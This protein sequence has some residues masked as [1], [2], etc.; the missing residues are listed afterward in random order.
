MCVKE[1]LTKDDGV[2]LEPM[3]KVE[4][5]VPD[6]YLGDIVGNLNAKRGKVSG[7]E[8]GQGGTTVHAVCPPMRNAAS[9]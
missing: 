6:D 2:L 1:G 7:M 4:V 8:T 5:F 9:A 3:M